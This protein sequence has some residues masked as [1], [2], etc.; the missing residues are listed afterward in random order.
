MPDDTSPTPAPSSPPAP[1]VALVGHCGFD[2]GSLEHAVLQAC[3]SAELLRINREDE[4]TDTPA[5]VWLVNRLLDG[6]FSA[7]TG[8]DLIRRHA[9]K[10]GRAMLLVSNYED[11]QAAAVEAGARPGFGKA[12]LGDATAKQALAEAIAAAQSAAGGEK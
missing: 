11:A 7:G 12:E 2:S 4:L 5:T 1:T 10:P 3:P 6:S 9:G 8:V